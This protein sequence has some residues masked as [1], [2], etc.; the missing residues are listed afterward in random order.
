MSKYR[1]KITQLS[2]MKMK[3]HGAQTT[4]AA[5]P[6]DRPKLTFMVIFFE[7]KSWDTP[8]YLSASQGWHAVAP[9]LEYE[10]AAHGIQWAAPG[11]SL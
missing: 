10:L 1:G 7:K 11:L 3:W 9:L 8:E 6:D 2:E 4:A 5:D